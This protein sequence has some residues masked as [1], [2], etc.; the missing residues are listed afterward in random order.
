M[1]E[2]VRLEIEP[3]DVV[4]CEVSNGVN[5]V[6]F[7]A[8]L[9]LASHEARI[10]GLHV[11]GAGPN[12]LGT[13]ALLGLVRWVRGVLDVDVLRIEGATRTTGA[14]PGRRLP[15]VISR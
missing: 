3:G 4:E 15:P 11:Y 5:A 10:S 2:L 13:G 9:E 12:T 7:L 14:G 1:W 8:T 6:V